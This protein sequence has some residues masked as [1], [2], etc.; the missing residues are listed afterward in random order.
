MM[1]IYMLLVLGVSYG[2][3]LLFVRWCDAQTSK[4]GQRG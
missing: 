2:A 4:G 3:M 1:D